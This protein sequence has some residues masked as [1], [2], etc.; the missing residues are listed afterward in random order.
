MMVVRRY[1][2]YEDSPVTK[3]NLKTY[4]RYGQ[5]KILSDLLNISY[6]RQVR[7]R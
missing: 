6:F 4:N 2:R 3:K 1:K 5:T 7:G